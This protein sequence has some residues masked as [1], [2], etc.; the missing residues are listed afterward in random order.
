M[1]IPASGAK[2]YR[3]LA[4]VRAFYSEAIKRIETLPGVEAAGVVS[5]LPFGGNMDM[6]GFHI[7]EKPLANPA[8]APSAERYSVSPD[9]LRAMGIPLLRGRGFTEQDNANAPL[10]TLINRTAAQRIWPNEDPVGKRIR[11][12]AVDNPLRTIVGV[13][14][15]VNHYDLETAPDLQAYVPHAQWTD[16]YMLLVVRTTTDPGALTGPVRQPIHALDPDVPLHKVDT[17]SQLVSASVEQ[18][19]FPLHL[20]VVFVE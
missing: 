12:G 19:S 14:G 5:N 13:V 10:V 4:Q 8:E 6:Y 15:D 2:K 9:Y 3:D 16:S 1:M 11:L 18:C 20:I 17:M 7:E